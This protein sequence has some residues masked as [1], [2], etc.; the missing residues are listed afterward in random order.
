[1][2]RYCN[3][4]LIVIIMDGHESTRVIFWPIVTPGGG[5]NPSTNIRKRGRNEEILLLKGKSPKKRGWNKEKVGEEIRNS[6][7]N[8]FPVNRVAYNIETKL[9]LNLFPTEG[10]FVL[11]FVLSLWNFIPP[12]VILFYNNID[13]QK[14]SKLRT[15]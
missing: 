13:A 5:R 9:S 3:C 4:H 6:G 12:Y 11:M 7:Q 1:M 10:G 2:L 14:A 8:I 15:N